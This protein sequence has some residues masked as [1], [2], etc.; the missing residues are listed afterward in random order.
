MEYLHIYDLIGDTKGG[1]F[2]PTKLIHS[3]GRIV[4]KTATAYYYI[5]DYE[6]SG[7]SKRIARKDLNTVLLP[8]G[9][10]AVLTI[11]DNELA[12]SLFTE[13]I[14]ELIREREEDISV[15]KQA[16]QVVEAFKD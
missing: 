7:E 9:T 13:Y 16:R 1:I 15:Y 12:R 8:E 3:K 11:P 2:H 6:M 5:T 4:K 14:D 10:R